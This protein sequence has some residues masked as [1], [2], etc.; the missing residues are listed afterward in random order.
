[1]LSCPHP[2]SGNLASALP[3]FVIH[4][5]IVLSSTSRSIKWFISVRSFYQTP[6]WFYFLLRTYHMYHPSHRP[7]FNL[8]NKIMKFF[9]FPISFSVLNHIIHSH[10]LFLNS[11]C[12]HTVQF[13]TILVPLHIVALRIY[14][15]KI[16]IA[17]FH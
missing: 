2:D 5:S 1:M 3:S 4:F 11:L 7:S 6:V 13:K 10:T 17:I 16:L 12:H 9:Q 14:M 15:L 8:P